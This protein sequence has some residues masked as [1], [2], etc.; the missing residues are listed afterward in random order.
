MTVCVVITVLSVHGNG[1]N[2][3]DR[4][5]AHNP[6]RTAPLNGLRIPR[7]RLLQTPPLTGAYTQRPAPVQRESVLMSFSGVH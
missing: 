6:V 1:L 7:R 4:W 2:R 3:T 5:S